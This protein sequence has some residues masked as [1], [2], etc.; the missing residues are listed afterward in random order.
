MEG[1]AIARGELIGFVGSSGNASPD[2]PHL[3]FAVFRLG[4]GRRW[5]DGLALNPYPLLK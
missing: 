5:W 3:H 1:Q 4:P 2:A